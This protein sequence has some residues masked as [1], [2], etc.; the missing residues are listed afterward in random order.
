MRIDELEK[1]SF[2]RFSV[3]LF[4]IVVLAAQ[5]AHAREVPDVFQGEWNS[6]SSACGAAGND[7]R[8]R[9]NDDSIA[10]HESEGPIEVFA[11]QGEREIAMI[12]SLQGEGER[13]QSFRHFR[14]SED[15]SRLT[16]ITYGRNFVRHR[17]R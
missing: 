3:A 16:D 11:T 1:C 8:L 5:S 7:T 14:L 6:K 12:V 2:G 17:C 10:F 9:I 13:W 15:G 4:A